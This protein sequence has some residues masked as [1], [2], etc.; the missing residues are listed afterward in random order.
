MAPAQNQPRTFPRP[1][2]VCRDKAKE[3]VSSS[4]C[5]C[6]TLIYFPSG[7]HRGGA[8]G[9]LRRERFHVR[10]FHWLGCSAQIYC[11]RKN[12][13]KDCDKLWARGDWKRWGELGIW[14]DLW[15]SLEN[16]T[17]AP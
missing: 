2:P 12:G 8:A 9:T 7:E 16:R 15:K 10:V 4:L 11:S 1:P 17:K 5:T 14:R 13:N 3:S 6:E